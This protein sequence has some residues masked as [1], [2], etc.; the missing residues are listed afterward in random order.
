MK[1]TGAEQYILCLSDPEHNFRKDVFKEYKEN[2]RDLRKPL[3]L[4]AVREHAIQHY[5]P[6]IMKGLEADDVMGITATQPFANTDYI[7]ATLDKDLDQIP[8]P[9][10]NLDTKKISLPEHRDCDLIAYKQ[11]L[12]G[13]TIDNYGGCPGV[14]ETTAHDIVTNPHL[15]CSY[16]HTFKSGKRK[17]MSETRW[18]RGDSCTVWEAVVSE[19]EKAGKT[20]EDA[21][22]QMRCAYILQHK[23]YDFVGNRPDL[24]RPR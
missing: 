20:K 15:W 23:D 2:R 14:G 17:G 10:Y 11:A 1:N 4:D 5:D 19:F 16:T 6:K 18:K 12:M 3:I 8:V 21:L 7:I 13:D 22:Q 24:W 9:I